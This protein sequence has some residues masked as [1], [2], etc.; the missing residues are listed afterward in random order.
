MRDGMVTVGFS[1]VCAELPGVLG[2]TGFSG[3]VVFGPV[4]TVLVITEV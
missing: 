3:V 2:F 1:S 4:L